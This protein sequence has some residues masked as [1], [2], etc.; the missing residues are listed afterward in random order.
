LVFGGDRERRHHHHEDEEVVDGQALFDDVAGEVLAAVV[1]SGDEPEHDAE[2]AR[3]GDVEDRRDDR[4]AEA[5]LAGV[6]GPRD[7]QVEHEQDADCRDG[8][9]PSGE[10]YVEH[11][12]TL[13]PN[14]RPHRPGCAVAPQPGNICPTWSLTARSPRCW[15]VAVHPSRAE[16]CR[17]TRI[18]RR[19]VE[20][21]DRVHH[22]PPCYARCQ[23]PG[24]NR[25]G[26]SQTSARVRGALGLSAHRSAFR[27]M[28]MRA[29]FGSVDRARR[30]RGA[31][32]E[33][34]G[35]RAE[36]RIVNRMGGSS[37]T[38][39]PSAPALIGPAA[40]TRKAGALPREVPP[41]PVCPTP[42]SRADRSRAWGG[43]P[44]RAGDRSHTGCWKRL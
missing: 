2:Y 31:D 44:R 32:G 26:F 8:R 16:R 28:A 39:S 30:G 3:H 23:G 19:K 17:N 42:Q 13:T 7:E 9:C 34:P 33:T 21:H 4:L 10:A 22:L 18:D 1:P 24:R 20:D 41:R 36:G 40:V 37:K 11:R 27:P 25:S 12:L 35:C 15:A 6:A 29:S 43:F 5:D 14:C 38:A